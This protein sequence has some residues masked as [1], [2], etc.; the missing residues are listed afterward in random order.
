M[1]R[2]LNV[3][4]RKTDGRTTYDSN[5]ALLHYVHRAVI[6]IGNNKTKLPNTEI[7]SAGCTCTRRA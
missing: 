2:Y 5:T 3:T 1:V 4:D 7:V 6:V